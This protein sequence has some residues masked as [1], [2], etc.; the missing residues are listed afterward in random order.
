[1]MKYL[2]EH[3]S[4]II[5]CS[6]AAALALLFV[7][8]F[9][10][11]VAR[12]KRV[13]K[14]F[15]VV[16]LLFG[17][18]AFIVAFVAGAF[19]VVNKYQLLK[20]STVSDGGALSFLYAGKELFSIPKLG[21]AAVVFN[22]LKLVGVVAPF[23]IC[24]LSLI[25]MIAVTAKTYSKKKAKKIAETSVKPAKKSFEPSE[26]EPNVT[27][28]PVDEIE[29]EST[30]S[31]DEPQTFAQEESE[32][33]LTEPDDEIDSVEARNIVD[34]IDR[35]V[36][37]EH[38][39]LDD[40]IDDRLRRAIKEGYELTSAFED[41]A[42]IRSEEFKEEN[43][44][45]IPSSFN[46]S[47]EKVDYI[48]EESDGESEEEFSE[49]SND[50][51]Y[52]D[53]PE[54]NPYDEPFAQETLKET[55]DEPTEE[56]EPSYEDFA[57]A[58]EPDGEDEPVEEE[59]E[60]ARESYA[61]MSA[62][63][64]FDSVVTA[65]EKKS[66]KTQNLSSGRKAEPVRGDYDESLIPTRVRTIIRRPTAKNMEEIE[67]RVSAQTEQEK[68]PVAVAKAA[69]ASEKS[70]E[71]KKETSSSAKK[72]APRKKNGG[73]SGKSD[74]QTKASSKSG[75]KIADSKNDE[76]KA[77]KPTVSKSVVAEINNLPLTRK[78]IILNR[79]NAAAVFNEYLNGKREQEKK[80]I[81][82]SLNTII[83]K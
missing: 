15:D 46:E 37:G 50:E 14:G 55:E 48:E 71:Q 43:L 82:G 4:S 22:R 41:S 74:A 45:D 36:T 24:L 67:R 72:A 47:A 63:S 27:G 77:E 38:E 13:R 70:A 59:T 76:A 81:T 42:S 80:E 20:L 51:F 19:A 10:V 39:P 56:T 40:E 61:A 83:I 28:E 44:Q 17:S 25:A 52:A 64:Q 8:M 21:F 12:K 53:E 60:D 11:A 75:A 54:E 49:N 69:V 30:P 33:V 73:V 7:I 23:A 65:K 35:L 18:L 6:V 68:E 3:K 62:R 29:N 58:N 31:F 1:M 34:E 2:F 9:V 79:R 78:Y 16:K 66:E 26:P 57:F 5:F 32:F